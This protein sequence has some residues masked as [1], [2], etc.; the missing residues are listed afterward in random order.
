MEDELPL[1][2][3]HCHL[4][5][6]LFADDLEA[7]MDRA[8]RAGVRAVFCNGTSEVD[9]EKVEKLEKLGTRPCFPDVPLSKSEDQARENRG[10]SLV[11]L[12]LHPWYV[13]GRSSGWLE[14][15][16]RMVVQGGAGVGEIGL[17]RLAR[18]LDESAQ[19]ECFEAQIALAA[20]LGSPVT[21]HCVRAWERLMEILRGRRS[22]PPAMIFHAYG[23]SAELV[24]PLAEMGAYF[25]FAGSVLYDNRKTA[26]AALSAV[27]A[28]RLLIE[29]DAPDMPPPVEY[30]AYGLALPGGKVRNE[31]A[32]LRGILRGVAKLRGADEAGLAAQM[33][34]NAVT[35]LGGKL[36]TDYTDEH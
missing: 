33:W 9:W 19:E 36:S 7:V 28:E 25:S 23:G 14:R 15:L 21:I 30:L 26:R 12:G 24:A 2:D 31:P 13:A 22:L 11:F 32:N 29:S 35:L 20:R 10:A 17:D 27:P 3:A 6:E 18:P 34:R 1:I 16:E 4:Q 8:Q 5:D